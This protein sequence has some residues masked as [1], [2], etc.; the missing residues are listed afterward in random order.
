VAVAERYRR[1]RAIAVAA[2]AAG[3]VAVAVILLTQGSTGKLQNASHAQRLASR[4][5]HHAAAT[6]APKPAAKVAASP[7]PVHHSQSSGSG[8]PST[9]AT[10]TV[11]G[12]DAL[13]AR[14]H[15]LMVDGSYG[16]AIPVLRQAL[17]EAPTGSL[18][19]AY[20]LF[21]LG[22]SLRLA[23]DP[24]QAVQVLWQRM[25]I[26]NQTGVVRTELRL[27]LEALG[28]QASGGA[29]PGPGA[30][31]DHGG[32]GAPPGGGASGGGPPGPSAD[33]GAGQQNQG[34]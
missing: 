33:I 11:S 29:G 9:S 32:H 27:A 1:P 31:K 26:P 18:T 30:H 8:G 21:D 16:Q 22:R 3:A 24:R 25:Q 13:E 28:R 15:A 10:S 34:D 20:A 19:Y 4:P 14:G 7:A 6:S 23:G 12:A 17:A 2:L 5:V